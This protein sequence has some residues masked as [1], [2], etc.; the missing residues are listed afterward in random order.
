MGLWHVLVCLLDGVVCLAEFFL[1]GLV[2]ADFVPSAAPW[3]RVK[4]GQGLG[5]LLYVVTYVFF[6]K[7][8]QGWFLRVEY[9]ALVPGGKDQ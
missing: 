7:Y 6:C 4:L 9:L 3:G 5:V 8:D 1:A 2:L